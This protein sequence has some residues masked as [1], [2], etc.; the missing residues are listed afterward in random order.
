MEMTKLQIL[1]NSLRVEKTINH[2]QQIVT[3]EVETK[4][5][6]QLSKSAQYTSIVWTLQ[7]AGIISLAEPSSEVADGQAP[8]NDQVHCNGTTPDKE[9]DDCGADDAT[10]RTPEVTENTK[11]DTILSSSASTVSDGQSTKQSLKRKR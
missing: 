2:L 5:V 11:C 8:C 7:E 6:W 1:N 4:H 3:K 10:N 9:T